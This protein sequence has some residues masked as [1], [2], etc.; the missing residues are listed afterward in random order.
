MNVSPWIC[1][2]LVGEMMGS[3]GKEFIQWSV[4]ELTAWARVVYRK[5]DNSWIPMLRDGTS[6]EGLVIKKGGPFGPEGTVVE[7]IPAIPIDFWAYALAY[8][9][10]GH[11]LMWQM[12]R[13]IAMGNGFGD[14]GHT[15]GDLAELKDSIDCADPYAIMGFLELY[16]RTQSRAFLGS[17]KRIGD[18]ILTRR[19]YKGFFVPSS[20]HVYTKFN[21]PESLALLHLHAAN[22]L[23]HVDVPMIWPNVAF[24]ENAY[25]DKDP[26]DDT[27]LIYRL[28]ESS[29]PPMSL[30]EAAAIGD[31]N[32][33]KSLI[34]K[35]TD[36]DMRE[37]SFFK[38][39]LHR[40]A[41]RGHK[42][43]AELLLAEGADVN[44]GAT[45]ALHYAA[46]KGHKEIAELLIA[47]GADVNAKDNR[48]RTPLWWAKRRGHTEIVE[49]LR[50]H[51][52]E[53]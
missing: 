17:A 40:A 36:V 24:F 32:L 1:A 16:K 52:A 20:K 51:G 23:L 26:L 10:T 35:G 9:L 2:L 5:T 44:A 8:R 29:E 53:K 43:V 27:S 39:A 34:K 48:G 38:T 14:I 50:K 13:N 41:I 12:A 30:Q 46:E 31:V 3:D 33:A 28:T 11:D 47:K 42:D 37:D 7:P 21:S 22:V 18:N 49:L 45:T 6:L 4:E 25:R 19:F 15:S